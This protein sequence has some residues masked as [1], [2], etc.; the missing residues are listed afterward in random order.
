MDIHIDRETVEFF[1]ALVLSGSVYGWYCYKQGIKRG[2]D[3]SIFSLEDA[4]F[5]QIKDNGEVKRI[6][7][8]EYKEYLEFQN[9][10]E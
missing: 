6:S 10:E 5:L 9:Q 2:W 7:D 8:K 4:G 3:D 1:I